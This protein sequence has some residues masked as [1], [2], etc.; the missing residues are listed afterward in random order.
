MDGDPPPNSKAVIWR[1][2]PSQKIL[3]KV[4]A[5]SQYFEEGIQGVLLTISDQTVASSTEDDFREKI[6]MTFCTLDTKRLI[7]HWEKQAWFKQIFPG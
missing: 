6:P 1:N 2:C 5:M 4:L 3:D 7:D